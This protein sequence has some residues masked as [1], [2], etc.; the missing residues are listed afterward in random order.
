MAEQVGE[1]G[2]LPRVL[3]AGVH[4]GDPGTLPVTPQWGGEDT[5]WGNDCL[6]GV[7]A[8]P[9]GRGAMSQVYM[10]CTETHSHGHTRCP[11]GTAAQRRDSKCCYLCSAPWPL[12]IHGCAQPQAHPLCWGLPLSFQASSL[13][14]SHIPSG[15]SHLFPPG[16]FRKHPGKLLIPCPSGDI[17]I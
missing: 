17:C 6:S 9:G 4:L 8:R 13:P 1:N 3:E 5:E 15:P 7:T 10:S 12:L 2:E 11:T 16:T 14:L